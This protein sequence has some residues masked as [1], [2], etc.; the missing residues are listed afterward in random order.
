MHDETQAIIK[1][2]ASRKGMMGS[3]RDKNGTELKNH[4]DVRISPSFLGG[5]DA[6][7]NFI[8]KTMKSFYD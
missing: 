8:K 4:V 1:K 3:Q 5:D 6:L 2:H 7:W